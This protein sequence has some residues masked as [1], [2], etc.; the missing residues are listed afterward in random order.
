MGCRKILFQTCE[1]RIV[2]PIAMCESDWAAS[3]KDQEVDE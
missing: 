1:L 2:S 3:V